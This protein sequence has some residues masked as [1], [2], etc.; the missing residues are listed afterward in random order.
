MI[1][2]IKEEVYIAVYLILFG[3]YLLSTYDALSYLKKQIKMPKAIA[4]GSEIIFCLLQVYITYIF[5]YRLQDGYIPIYFILFMLLGWFI[6]MKFFKKGF[7]KVIYW[8]GKIITRVA[9]YIKKLLVN[10]FYSPQ[11]MKII[12]KGLLKTFT[13]IKKLVTIRKKKNQ[14]DEALLVAEDKPINIEEMEQKI[15]QK[16]LQ[17]NKNVV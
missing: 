16:D 3:V 9:P 14:Q 2:P 1:H 5:S 15:Y 7:I 17:D 4:I 13:R 12:R 10:L 6:Y 8:I 11:L